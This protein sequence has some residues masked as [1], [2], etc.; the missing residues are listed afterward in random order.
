MRV[1][2]QEQ[3]QLF[4]LSRELPG[5]LSLCNSPWLYFSTFEIDS[6]MKAYF[7]TC[8][9]TYHTTW[10]HDV[11]T[12]LKHNYSNPVLEPYIGQF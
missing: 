5:L 3:K 11:L 8:F 12:F 10:I 1:S 9:L 2:N 7:I 6:G 4:L